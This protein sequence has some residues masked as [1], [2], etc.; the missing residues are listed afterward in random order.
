MILICCEEGWVRDMRRWWWC[1]R[2]LGLGS[3]SISVGRSDDR[4]GRM[5]NFLRRVGW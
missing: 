2:G 3:C 4:T 1:L 5:E